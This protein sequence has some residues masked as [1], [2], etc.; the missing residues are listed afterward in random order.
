MAHLREVA[1]ATAVAL[2][3][4][5]HCTDSEMEDGDTARKMATRLS[6]VLLEAAEAEPLPPRPQSAL[7][8][9]DFS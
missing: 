6:K 9:R 5:A 8:Q 2:D 3:W 7:S 1:I 4:L